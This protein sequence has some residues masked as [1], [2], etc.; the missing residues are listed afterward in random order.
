MPRAAVCRRERTGIWRSSA[1]DHHKARARI[2]QKA[3]PGR[4]KRELPIRAIDRNA[5][6]LRQS[7]P[8]RDITVL[9][10]LRVFRFGDASECLVAGIDDD[11]HR[12]TGLERHG[13]RIDR[14]GDQ[15][16]IQCRALRHFDRLVADVCDG[17]CVG[18]RVRVGQCVFSLVLARRDA[19]T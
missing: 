4:L 16:K 13:R 3:V 18:G 1:Q 5:D 14:R 7:A 17:V 10:V 6:I 8:C 2:R 11:P 12:R 15:R 19:L 9:R